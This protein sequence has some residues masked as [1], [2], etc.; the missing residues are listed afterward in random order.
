M[1]ARPRGIRCTP[2]IKWSSVTT[3]CSSTGY[4][5]LLISWLTLRN[6]SGSSFGQHFPTGR[7]STT[8]QRT[9]KAITKGGSRT[10]ILIST[11]DAEIPSGSDVFVQELRG[12]HFER[13][14]MINPPSKKACH[15]PSVDGKSYFAAFFLEIRR[16]S[17]LLQSKYYCRSLEGTSAPTVALHQS[18]PLSKIHLTSGF[19][20]VTLVTA[21]LVFKNDQKMSK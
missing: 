10:A 17:F 3:A 14:L 1:P 8:V 19:S 20:A 7:L 21:L 5:R 12:N 4:P 18:L 2:R 15:H 9:I 13:Y 11:F 16:F 6:A